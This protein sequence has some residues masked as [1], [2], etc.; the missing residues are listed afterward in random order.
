MELKDKILLSRVGEMTL[1]QC[2]QKNWRGDTPEILQNARFAGQEMMLVSKSD[3]E[4]H[5]YELHY[6][7]FRLPDIDGIDRAKAV[8]EDFA[9]EVLRKRIERV[10]TWILFRRMRKKKRKLA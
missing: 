2:H 10:Q 6:L 9:K 4:L 1:K 7:G 5:L 3:E 8:A